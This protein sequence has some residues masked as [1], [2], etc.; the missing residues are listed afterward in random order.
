MEALDLV[1]AVEQGS[2]E[3]TREEIIEGIAEH[4]EEL[5]QLQGSWGRLIAALEENGEI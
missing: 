3:Y 1:L 4:K 2:Q 5:R